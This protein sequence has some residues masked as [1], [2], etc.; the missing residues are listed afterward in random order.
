MNK[1]FFYFVAYFIMFLI[2]M[3]GM[4]F[5]NNYK[6]S[7]TCTVNMIAVIVITFFQT[8]VINWS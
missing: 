4:T 3:V 5:D 7:N 1:L 8:V 6:I 2:H